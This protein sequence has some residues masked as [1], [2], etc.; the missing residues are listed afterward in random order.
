MGLTANITYLKCGNSNQK[1]PLSFIDKLSLVIVVNYILFL[2]ISTLICYVYPKTFP[3]NSFVAQFSLIKNFEKFIRVNR[4]AEFQKLKCIQGIRFYNMLLIIFFHTYTSYVGGYL[5]NTEYLENLPKNIVKLG[6]RN[7]MLFLVQTFFLFSSFLM[8]YHFYQT[9][10][11]RNKFDVKVVLLTFLN[12]YFRI[13]P[14][15][16]VLISM[17]TWIANFCDGPVKEIYS[18]VEYYNC[19]NNWWVSLLFI[20]NH[21]KPGEMCYFTTWYLAADTQLYALSLVVLS[22][23]WKYKKR[24]NYILTF[25]VFIGI[26]ASFITSYVYNLDFIYR[27]TPENVKTNNFRSFFFNAVYSSTYTNMAT[28][29]IGVW[30]GIVYYKSEK[31]GEYRKRRISF[32]FWLVLF[33]GLP[34]AVV[35]VSSFYYSRFAGALLSGILKPL[36][37]MGIAVGIY[38]MSSGVGGYIKAVCEWKPVLILGNLTYCTYLVQ[39]IVVFH[40][41]ATMRRPFYVSD[42]VLIKS[43]ARDAILSFTCGFFM[44]IFFEIPAANVKNLLLP[45]IRHQKNENNDKRTE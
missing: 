10:H 18:D 12:R 11:N 26:F 4:D 6:L 38:G 20:N 40:R 28:Y 44:H 23:I 21:Y 14:P 15:L 2:I 35:I 31:I 19:K 7:F 8:S 9:V 43:F 30:L 24:A 36:Y 45:R 16:A 5:E 22:I 32:A 25:F 33:A 42:F 34:I 39:I 27:L 29:M 3:A 1:H 37:A 41:T 17:V 13:L